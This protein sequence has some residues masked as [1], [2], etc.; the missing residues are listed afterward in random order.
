MIKNL[1]SIGSSAL[2]AS[3]VAL[4][5]Y[6]N[7]VA[8]AS[9]EGYVRRSVTQQ[10]RSSITLNGTSVGTGTDVQSIVRNLSTFLQDQYYDNAAEASM[11]SSI[12][13]NLSFT[14]SLFATDEDYGLSTQLSTFWN[15]WQDLSA[16]PDLEGTRLTTLNSGET[17]AG[18]LNS[19][20]SD[21]QQQQALLNTGIK[22]NVTTAN[23]IFKAVADLNTKLV[24][25]P[26]SLDLADQRDQLV[27][28][29]S[30]I[31]DVNVVRGDDGQITI[32]SGG[33]QT[34]VDGGHAYELSVEGP[35]AVANLDPDSD[36][37][38][39]VYFEGSSSDEFSIEFVTGGSA[40][41]GAGAAQFKVS[42][43]GGETWLSDESGDPILYKAGGADDKV[44]VD[45]V[46]IWFGDGTDPSQPATTDISAG[47]G[48]N[49]VPKS[50][51]YWHSTTGGMVNIT[52]LEGSESSKRLSGGSLAGQLMTRDE[53]IGGYADD[54]DAFAQNL[55]WEVNR[56]H[57]QGAGLS[58]FDSVT[59]TYSAEHTDAPLAE[60]GL[61]FAD[62]VESGGLSLAL[63]DADTG[64]SLG[65]TAVDFSSIV[66]PG[67]A[68]FDPAVH[69]L[70]DVRDAVN[71]TFP[72]QVSASISNGALTITA[73]EGVQ[74][75]FADDSTGLL[76]ATGINTFFDGTDASSIQLNATTAADP[77]RVCAGHVNGEGEYNAGDNTT[78]A[79]LS[80]LSDKTIDLKTLTG[81]DSTSLQEFLDSIVVGV[82]A[83]ASQANTNALYATAL[84]AEVSTRQESLSGVNLDE[85]LTKIMQQQNAYQAAAKLIQ[86]AGDMFD[87]IL[88]LPQ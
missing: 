82:G 64:D 80:A 31:M 43:D 11:W 34:L 54:L 52:P 25:N 39:G 68:N 70:E 29:L 79:A 16:S 27:N 60:S 17:L 15:S 32:L 83:D 18:L 41:G 9:T 63:Y 55:I 4:D 46:S 69:S 49:I 76:A 12:S 40:S 30:T 73:A 77:D 84:T 48:F 7:N 19:V 57:S 44:T 86:V 42:L 24:A 66:P 6:G 50:G 10:E 26:N 22:Q 56:A 75:Q 35:R 78:A 65:V 62:R 45:G 14:E 72:G 3:Q 21:L 85:E 23:T 1:L 53:Y 47:D 38:G 67:T 59:G 37:D 51:V 5:V 58:P 28:Q 87:T 36:F 33:G 13:G 2:T 88:S 74:F 8:N 61:D 81:D 71:A 20:A